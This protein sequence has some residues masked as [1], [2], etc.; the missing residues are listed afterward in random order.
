MPYYLKRKKQAGRTLWLIVRKA[1]NKVVGTSTSQANAK[2][3]I[4][5]R[6]HNE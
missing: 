5:H 1:D 4:W 6:M 3:S 2:G